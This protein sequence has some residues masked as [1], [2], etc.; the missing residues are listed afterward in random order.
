VVDGGV[1][2]SIGSSGM[3]EN[4]SSNSTQG[5]ILYNSATFQAGTVITLTDSS[6]NAIFSFTPTVTSNSLLFSAP[7]IVNG[8]S[9]LIYTGGVSTGTDGF[10]LGGT[11]SGTKVATVTASSAGTY[12]TNG[13]A[14]NTFGT[15]TQNK[16]Q[17]SR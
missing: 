9:Y 12:S 5:S 13:G 14:G 10:T 2:A 1:V 4:F 8:N 3:A 7:G 6:G 16:T 17:T 11:V 15:G